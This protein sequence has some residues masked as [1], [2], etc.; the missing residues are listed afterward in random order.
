MIKK[1]NVKYYAP[2]VFFLLML[3]DGQLT[4]GVEN[5]MDN[6]YF[7]SAHILLLAFLMSVPNLSKRY[8]LITS[9]VLG[10]VCDSYYL[11]IIGIYT[12]ALAATVMMMFRFQRVVHTNLL[13]AFFGMIIFVTAYEL[14]A[15]G[16]QVIFSISKVAPILF[17]TKVLGPTLIFNMLLFVLLSY[18]L[19]RL[20]A[21]E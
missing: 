21:N 3:I 8:L 17:V 13:T 9:L 2:V 4:H 5:L 7:P 6:I 20:F 11:G 15:V 10:L 19:K 18:P 12:V 1:E 16:L 14:I